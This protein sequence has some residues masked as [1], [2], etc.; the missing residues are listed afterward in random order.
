MDVLVKALLLT[1]DK[2]PIQSG[3][4][5]TGIDLLA[6]GMAG[7]GCSNFIIRILYH[8]LLI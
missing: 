5:K 7:S 4:S 8:I 2:N 1:S 3:L 6:S